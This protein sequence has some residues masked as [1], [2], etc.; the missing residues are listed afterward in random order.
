[1]EKRIGTIL[2]LVE[3]TDMVGRMNNAISDASPIIIGRQGIS[4]KDRSLN[5]ISLVVEGTTDQIGALT[6]K[7]GKLSGITVKSVLMKNERKE[8]Q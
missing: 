8:Y 6:G 7:L 4:L 1:M 2:I 5:V 3:D